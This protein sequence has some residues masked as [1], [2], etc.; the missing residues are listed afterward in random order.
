MNKIIIS[1]SLIILY[2]PIFSQNSKID[3]LE[4]ILANHHET[5]IVKVN[6]LTGLAFDY[7]NIDAEKSLQY[8]MLADS[9]SDIIHYKKGKANSY[10][11]IGVYYYYKSDFKRALE[12][13]E[14]GLK[15]GEEIG[16]KSII[17]NF[18]NNIGVIYMFQSQ[19]DK[20]LE[21]YDRKLEMDIKNQDT[22]EMCV[23]YNN[24]GIV[25]FY[26]G[27]YPRAMEYYQKTLELSEKINDKNLMSGAYGNIG[28]I[29]TKL[30]EYAKS[31]ELT[32][33]SYQLEIELGNKFSISRMALSMGTEYSKMDSLTK[34]LEYYEKSLKTSKEIDYKINT[35]ICYSNI[36]GIYSKQNDYPKAL[37]Y[38]KKGL[39]L[40]EEIDSKNYIAA[41]NID[42]SKLYYKQ[43]KY[44]LAIKHGE[45]GYEI[46]E[47]I[48]GKVK[49]K[50]A[51]DILAKVY[52]EMGD[53]KKAYK[54]HLEYK[55]NSDSI[56]NESN[57]KEIT[58]IENKYEFE[59]ERIAIEQVKKDVIQQAETKYQKTIKNSFIIGFVLM[60]VFAIIIFINL[61]KIRKTNLLLSIKNKEIASQ[62]EEIQT[63]AEELE[64]KNKNLTELSKFK[65]LMTDTIIHDLKNPLNYII[66]A[67]KDKNI[68][69]TGYNMLNI[70]LNILDINKA[71]ATE[72]SVK[73]KKQNVD[74]LIDNAVS[75]VEFLAE[76][77]NLD[78]ERTITKDFKIKA[79]K[80]LTIRILV[81]LLTNAIKFSHINNKITIE[82]SEKGKSMQIDV[83]DYGKGISQENLKNIFDEYSQ[84]EATKS[85]E[86]QS[87]GLG[88]TF[89]RIAVEAQNAKI[90]VYSVLAEKTI[91]SLTFP[92]IAVSEK[93]TEKIE[94]SKNKILFTDEEKKSIQYIL[95][96]LKDTD[97]FRATELTKLLNTVE[98]SSEN[99][100]LWKQKIK[101]AMLATNKELYEKLIDNV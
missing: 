76:Q 91:F 94:D 8:A 86:I 70:V 89:C 13:Y 99:I 78:F 69:Q 57:I 32:K 19:Y 84:V 58:N 81:N 6:L 55:N 52:A 93:I 49:I 96:K 24:F 5:D 1:L 77:K 31:L 68:R 21:Y 36:G 30:N 43:K 88:L 75:Q 97:I 72:L 82:A 41:I 46:A 66:G 35:S 101:T 79:D 92:L 80:D 44:S 67:A 34:A 33:K 25:Y 95:P 45:K 73:L 87:T 23:A 10:N 28:H 56:Y 26:K 74:E 100:K 65:K 54:Y 22:T 29:Y 59:K 98:N 38:L 53:Y 85:G 7:N 40:A 11:V 50:N 17:N 2:L 42:L 9:L 90:D 20:A 18:I 15:I 64:N 61:T 14:K 37:K 63:Q 12:Y 60:I 3:S 4:N 47:E 39:A 16:N 62:K 71:Q 27:N 48:D 83:I 51:S